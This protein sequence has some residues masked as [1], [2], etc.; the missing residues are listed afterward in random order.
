MDRIVHA[1]P[2]VCAAQLGG[3]LPASNS[4]GLTV[5]GLV[6]MIGSICGVLALVAWCYVRLLGGPKREDVDELPRSGD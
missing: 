1:A 5:A 2:V 4:S 3:S 6:F